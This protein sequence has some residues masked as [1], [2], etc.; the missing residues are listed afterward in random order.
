MN[1]SVEGSV[2]GREEE[3]KGRLATKWE[4][5]ERRVVTIW[6]LRWEA[7]LALAIALSPAFALVPLWAGSSYLV[8]N[9]ALS[10]TQ[11]FIALG[12]VIAS[13]LVVGGVQRTWARSRI[14][15]LEES[16]AEALRA[17]NRRLLPLLLLPWIPA[18]FIPKVE[19]EK[20]WLVFF[21]AGVLSITA[22]IATYKGRR[23]EAVGEPSASGQRLATIFAWLLPVG[24]GILFSLK[25]ITH[26]RG[27]G[28]RAFDL[29]IYDNIL[30]HTSHGN[31]LGTS[32]LRSGNHVSA[33]FDPLLILFAPFYRLYPHAEFLLVLQSF[34]LAAGAIPLF[35]LTRRVLGNAWAGL[36]LVAVYLLYP[37]MHGA[38]LY[39]FHSLTLAG[40]LIIATMAS[41]EAGRVRLYA[42]FL[43]LLLLTREDMSLVAMGI[44]LYILVTGK[45]KKLGLGTMGV[46]AVYLTLVKLFI[47]PDPGLFMANT[48]E[49]YGYAYYYRDL[50]PYSRE[51]ARG[52][53][54]SL[55]VN[56]LFVLQHVTTEPKLRFFFQLFMPLLFLPFFVRRGKIAMVY[57]FVF[58]FLSSREAVHSIAFQYTTVLTP[59]ALVL[60]V[61]ALAELRRWSLWKRWGVDAARLNS[62]LLVGM[63]VATAT[64]SFKF[65]AI[66]PSNSFRAGFV[67][68]QRNL[69]PAQL[70]AYEWVRESARRIPQE[71]AVSAS[72]RLSPH[73]ANREKS[74]LFP[75][76]YEESD[77]LLVHRSD[78]ARGNGKKRYDEMVRSRKFEKVSTHEGMEL[79]KR[80][81]E[82][83]AR[84][85]S[86][87]RMLP[88]MKRRDRVQGQLRQ[89]EPEVR[90]RPSAVL[91]LVEPTKDD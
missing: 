39:D 82:G 91:P 65:G 34:W 18:L 17:I 29:S 7:G 68:L 61:L 89:K 57:G 66:F 8:D 77:Y 62:G 53:L 71:A 81:P 38:N 36:A 13:L 30:W 21:V 86:E 5:L 85:P 51:G 14:R 19:S 52:L 25:A 27:L 10:A 24:Y 47:M 54:L 70:E 23:A 88:A 50:I 76:R 79:W 80:A 22:A 78:V 67:R 37:A 1:G 44:G 12:V 28:T 83:K 69:S 46:A 32:I 15:R 49:S 64:L 35:F 42:F 20:P 90:P 26:H 58:L 45:G 60:A 59:F 73:V 87:T 74:Y 11:R 75:N 6:A 41:L 2:P 31:L 63:V 56:P 48:S 9:K 55:I 43:A 4:A 84:L 72:S 33:H 3:P 16:W 40:P